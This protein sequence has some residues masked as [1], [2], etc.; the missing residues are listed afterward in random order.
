MPIRLLPIDVSSKIAA[1]EVVERPSS[2][3]K[4][5][6]E[7]S[8][9]AGATEISVEL[10]GG[11]IELIRVSD[12]GC[13]I[14]ADEVPLAFQRFA[15]S[16]VESVDDLGAI[17]T[18][19][20]RGEAL[21]SIAAV[22]SVTLLTRTRESDSGTRIDIIE[23]STDRLEPAGASP[24]TVITVRHL[25]RNFPARRKFLR[26]AASET[27]RVQTLITKFALAYP[28]IRFRLEAT[29]IRAFASTG[30]GDLRDAVTAVYG[31]ETGKAMLML[32]SHAEEGRHDLPKVHGM[33]GP[34]SID[35]AN[36][37]YISLFVNRRWV[38]NRAL[39]FALEQAYHG[40]MMERRYP[41]AVVNVS[42]DPGEID[43]N[44][45]PSKTE[46]RF[47]QENQVF[48]AIQEAVR[49]TLTAHSPVPTVRLSSAGSPRTYPYPSANQRPGAFWPIAPFR[50][51]ET[52]AA[53]AT[54]DQS[55]FDIVMP[56]IPVSAPDGGA[57]AV[58]QAHL[59]KATLPVLRVLGQVNNTYIIAEGPDGVYMID[60]H[61]AHERVLYEKVRA[62][63]A[64]NSPSAQSLLEPLTIELSPQQQ[65][66]LAEHGEAISRM[67]VLLEPF[68][69]NVYLLRGVPAM[70][71]AGDPAQ[72]IIE[73]LDIAEDG[74]DLH[75]WE[76]K[77]AASIACH[78]A[79]RAGKQLSQSEMS[80]LTRQLEQCQQPHNCPHGRPTM[81]HMSAGHLERE[82]G[83]R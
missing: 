79:V 66:L 26:S 20:F 72:A 35:R 30:N 69:A 45:H 67:G 28:E 5:L 23:G 74:G 77:A 55:V 48:S 21:P 49:S 2:V 32:T 31:L 65:E 68:G 22:A 56:D 58:E 73:M 83:R 8:I 33:I 57:S 37:S 46:V 10:T 24:G 7:N 3:V 15:T 76:E 29:G 75:S 50:P 44:V 62:E 36:R 16:K 43:V 64:A 71:S 40:F 18:L 6:V 60:Q 54:E 63:A 42:I 19:G 78:G 25:F 70:L 34:P 1:G 9:D 47:R 17:Q 27:T 14:P 12:D 13:G 41:I 59:H 80:A 81:I 51:A 61:A 53:A 4:E 11:G 38:Q 52:D 39:S 82:F